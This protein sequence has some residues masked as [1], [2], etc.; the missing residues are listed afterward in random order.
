MLRLLRSLITSREP[1]IS[2]SWLAEH[3]RKSTRVEFVGVHWA[4]PINKQRN[5]AAKWNSR[6]ERRSA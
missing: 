2:D 5:E 6:K 4:W 1:C 3:E